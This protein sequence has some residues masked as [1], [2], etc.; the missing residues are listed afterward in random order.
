[1]AGVREDSSE[2]SFT[3]AVTSFHIYRRVW[4]PHLE[5]RLS[6]ER[7]PGNA[8]DRFA[9][10]VREHSDTRVDEEAT[11]DLSWTPTTKGRPNLSAV[12]SMYNIL[13]SVLIIFE[14]ATCE[15]YMLSINAK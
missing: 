14:Q 4:L 3:A 9:I 5:Q 8:D 13:K 12:S 11:I 6:A 10:A 1:M 7:E 15:I 2:F